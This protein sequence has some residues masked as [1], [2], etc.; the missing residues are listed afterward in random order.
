MFVLTLFVLDDVYVII[1]ICCCCVDQYPMRIRINSSRER[2]EMFVLLTG[3][4]TLKKDGEQ[5]HTTH[6]PGDVFGSLE[7]FEKPKAK[8]DE[9]KRPKA[10]DSTLMLEKGC[11]LRLSFNDY[12]TQIVNPVKPTKEEIKKKKS[13]YEETK[14]N[15]NGMMDKALTKDVKKFLGETGL[16]GDM[17]EEPPPPPEIKSNK[18]PGET[19][20]GKRVNEMEEQQ[21]GSGGHRKGRRGR[22]MRAAAQIT[23]MSK[24]KG[25]P[26]SAS[27]T[28]PKPGADGTGGDVSVDY[29]EDG[30]PDGS[31]VP[32]SISEVPVIPA[33]KSLFSPVGSRISHGKKD[34][35]SSPPSRGS[36]VPGRKLFGQG[37]G[38]RHGRRGSP[39]GSPP[40]RQGSH[41][42]ISPSRSRS[43]SRQPS[44][45]SAS[46]GMGQ[47]VKQASASLLKQ[48]SFSHLM[49]Q[50]T[51]KSLTQAQMASNM[52]MGFD[53]AADEYSDYS[54][55][56]YSG[57][58]YSGSSS[59]FDEGS[60]DTGSDSGA[61]FD[62]DDDGIGGA[63]GAVESDENAGAAAQS[64]AN[65]QQSS[66]MRY[67]MLGSAN[68]SLVF[69]RTD[70]RMVYII[71]EGSVRLSMQKHG[72]TPGAIT[73]T[74]SRVGVDTKHAHSV[75]SLSVPLVCLENGAIISL[76]EECFSV[77]DHYN[78]ETGQIEE[79]VKKTK[80][81]SSSIVSQ[82][83]HLDIENANPP[84]P[85][86]QG[87]ADDTSIA[88]T[89][90]TEEEDSYQPME[91]QQYDIV[92]TFQKPTTYIAV[93]Y[94]V[95]RAAMRERSGHVT[96]SISRLIMQIGSTI[97]QR[98]EPLL[99]W[100]YGNLVVEFVEERKKNKPKYRKNA[101]GFTRGPP[102][103]VHIVPGLP[104]LE[105][106]ELCGATEF[107]FSM[108]EKQLHSV[109][110]S[111][112]DYKSMLAGGTSASAGTGV[113]LA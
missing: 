1:I 92:L 70:T 29:V 103:E 59:G 35:N 38:D 79:P 107:N 84:K 41:S 21:P 30:A 56:S 80:P 106:S 66:N 46:L 33:P 61:S 6:G 2:A 58:S 8:Y 27:G 72:G 62:S 71:L 88:A 22:K 19:D 97:S 60:V 93:P 3:C 15:I 12:Y 101:A 47:L 7:Y 68:R 95:F 64:R 111:N 13:E 42:S 63:G 83:L 34:R 40:R 17:L 24:A 10:V 48:P 54:G 9:S 99:P 112:K 76:P 57:S 49:R 113:G 85:L 37:D 11:M 90:V 74:R 73:C 77:A 89:T 53:A 82:K 65:P 4:C 26:G 86:V 102:P 75:K 98:I 105:E 14:H 91:R 78:P 32:V 43:I 31:S 16:L 18:L 100:L 51:G 25:N 87:A 36:P 104:D 23:V 20:I 55:S 52:L 108:R 44:V 67:I 50:N 94:N 96:M 28:D 109:T 81:P 45:D 39:D 110:H 69:R 5:E